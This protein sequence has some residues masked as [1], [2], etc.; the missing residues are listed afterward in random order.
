MLESTIEHNT[1][2]RSA[3]QSAANADAGESGFDA[4]QAALLASERLTPKQMTWVPLVI[5]LAAVM[6]LVGGMVMLSTAGA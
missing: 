2:L 4:K 5:P 6:L 3:A 1:P